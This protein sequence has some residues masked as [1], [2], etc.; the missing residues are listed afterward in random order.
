MI[1]SMINVF[2]S[3][4]FKDLVNVDVLEK[5][6]QKALTSTG[7]SP[8][9]FS[10][11]IVIDDDNTLQKLNAQYS[12]VDET[13][14]V[15]SFEMNEKDPETGIVYLGDIVIS[16]PRAS[17]QA[18][19]AGHS[20]MNELM[21]LLIHGILHLIGYD[22]VSENDKARMWTLQYKLFCDLDLGDVKI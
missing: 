9:A 10:L 11:T 17:E 7:Y 13:T 19:A 15:L 8:H 6:A 12:G 1:L 5:V 18:L 14:D 20:V 2:V 21:L 4:S 16:F 22:H 3:A